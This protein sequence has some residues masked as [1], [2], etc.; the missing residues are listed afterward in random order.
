MACQ[1]GRA[2][3]IRG[4]NES[5]RVRSF[6]FTIRKSGPLSNVV[7]CVLFEQL[8][9]AEDFNHLV[10]VVA[11][12]IFVADTHELAVALDQGEAASF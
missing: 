7:Q 5:C 2:D 6:G 1:M 3:H 12:S 11:T 10:I 9:V 8:A 4:I